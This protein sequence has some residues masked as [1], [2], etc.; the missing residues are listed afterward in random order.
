M[1]FKHTLI[2][3]TSFKVGQKRKNFKLVPLIKL[4]NTPQYVGGWDQGDLH[5]DD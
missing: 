5:H 1:H 2:C 3:H 4:D